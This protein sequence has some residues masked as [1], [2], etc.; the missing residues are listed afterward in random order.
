MKVAYHHIYVY[1]SFA[2]MKKILDLTD[3]SYWIQ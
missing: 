2:A 3:L 1:A